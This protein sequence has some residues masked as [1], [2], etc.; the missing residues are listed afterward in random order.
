MVK[1]CPERRERILSDSE[2]I[3]Y[4]QIESIIKGLWKIILY[5]MSES[6]SPEQSK[7]RFCSVF[8]EYFAKLEQCEFLTMNGPELTFFKDRILPFI[9]SLGLNDREKAHVYSTLFE[10]ICILIARPFRIGG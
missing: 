4:E 8:L 6:P 10:R 5:E 1:S 3:R 2:N 7:Y 9:E